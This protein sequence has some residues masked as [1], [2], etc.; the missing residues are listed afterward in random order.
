ML[1]FIKDNSI[2]IIPNNLKNN[3]IKYIRLFSKDINIKI[4]S[5]DEFIKKLTFTYDEKTIYELMKLED[6]NY[7]NA[8]LYINNMCYVNNETGVS[9][10]DSLFSMKNNIDKFL[11]KNESFK[12]LIKDK[13][14]IVYGYDY[15]TKFQKY[16]LNNID[17][18]TFINK[19]YN[20]Y[21]HSV[22]K[23]NNLEDE[24]IFIAEKISELISNGTDINKIYL[25][26]LDNNYYTVIKKIFKMYNIPVNLNEKH[27][28]YNTSIAKYFIYNLNNN[29]DDLFNELNNKF[30]IS[31][32]K[33]KSIY[34]KLIDVINKFYFTKDY[35]SVKENIINVIKNTYLDNKKY[36][37]AINEIDILN[38]VI[39]DDEYVF[40][41]GFNLNSIPK[42]IKDEAYITDNIKPEYIEKSY[43]EN[44]INKE[45]YYKVINNIRNITLT[46]KEKYLNESFYPS[47]LIDEYKMNVTQ[48]EVKISKYSDETNKMLFAKS[49]D[50]LI[51][52]NIKDDNLGVLINN[53]EINY[54]T[55]DNKFSGINKNSLY[56]YLKN[57][58]NLSYSSMDNY[59]HCAFRFYL[60]N[61][62]KLDYFEETIQV[63]IGNLFHYVLSKAFI[64]G[65]DFDNCVNY[66]ICNNP[67]PK[68]NKNEYFLNK[69]IDELKFMIDIISYQNTLMDMNKALY[70]QKIIV[71]KPGIININF[72]GFIDKLLMKDKN[73]V[74]IDYKTYM[75]DINLNYLPYGLSLQLP[76]YLYLTKNYI[77]DAE[78]VGFYLQQILFNKFSKDKNKTLKELKFNNSKLKGYSIS[79]EDKLSMF[80]S[81]YVNSEL[82]H[83][84]KV[85]NKGFGPYSKVLTEKQ[86]DNIVKLT[87]NKINECGNAIINAKF[88]INTKRINNKN[89]GCEYC[90]FKDICFVTNKDFVE[91]DEIKDINFL[92]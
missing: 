63:Y 28:L 81:T 13:D 10:L 42:T 34:N 71:E 48:K 82:I 40:L 57:S 18:V 46:Y 24:V 25:S 69:V 29:I 7:S 90:K 4:F 67:Y 39:N 54:M 68:S 76:V 11:I 86:I 21:E 45:L 35:I 31:K 74:I 38:N 43:E 78:I 58:F 49:I 50:N 20:E 61:I 72:K 16:I 41:V 83:S 36:K 66:Y 47:L 62:L 52:F 60:S 91:L 33:N 14:I 64:D 70:E 56:S 8:K 53:Y 87:D 23:F 6:I 77:K 2:L 51:K 22:Y 75:V 85:T 55:Y 3:I 59:Y 92:D 37:N 89:I 15:I 84:M 17:N 5:M 73:V 26:N 79:N 80:D 30:D 1:D 27:S 88:D 65:F 12:L 44:I 9:K 19:N 32:K